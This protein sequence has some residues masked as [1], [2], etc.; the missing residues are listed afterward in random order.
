MTSAHS[1]LDERLEIE[2]PERVT[3][4]HDLAGIGSRF[5][6]GAIGGVLMF[7][8]RRAKRIGDYAAGTIVVRERAEP[9]EVIS[10]APPAGEDALD[11]SDLSRARTFVVRAPQLIPS[12]R[13]SI[14]RR[15]ADEIARRH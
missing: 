1:L 5:A 7:V 15:L 10:S 2:T 3:I 6:A 14:A 11:A 8:N 13:D 9:L 4:T 12:S